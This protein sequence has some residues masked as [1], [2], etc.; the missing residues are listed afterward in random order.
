MVIESQLNIKF[1]YLI[2][3][4]VG[5]VICVQNPKHAKKTVRNAV[6]SEARLLT[7]GNF[8]TRFDH[9]LQLIYQHNSVL[10]KNDIIN[11]DRQDDTAAYRTFCSSNFH[12]CLITD[13]QVKIRMEGFAI[14]IFVMNKY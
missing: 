8:L 5:P 6:M 13:Y 10:Y 12:Q 2:F 7:F 11:L 1:S 3:N 4:Y 14:Y 9:F